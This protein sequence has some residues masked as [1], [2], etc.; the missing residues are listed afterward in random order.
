MRKKPGSP[1][2]LWF[3]QHSSRLKTTVRRPDEELTRSRVLLRG[4]LRGQSRREDRKLP[5]RKPLQRVVRR[6]ERFSPS[7]RVPRIESR[8][9]RIEGGVAASQFRG[10]PDPFGPEVWGLANAELGHRTRCFERDGPGQWRRPLAPMSRRNCIPSKQMRSHAAY[11][12]C[13]ASCSV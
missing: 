6:L 8:V 11:A 13:W 5:I 3:L 1:R 2:Y 10:A 12:A 9:P 7:S 4:Y